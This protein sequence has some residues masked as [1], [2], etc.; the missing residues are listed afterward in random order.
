MTFGAN[1]TSMFFENG[2]SVG[3]GLSIANET[4]RTFQTAKCVI[5]TVGSFGARDALINR[6]L[7]RSQVHVEAGTAKFLHFSAETACVLVIARNRIFSSARAIEIGWTQRGL[8]ICGF[9]A[10]VAARAGN[11]GWGFSFAEVTARAFNGSFVSFGTVRAGRARN[12]IS[13][14][15]SA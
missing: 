15:N 1:F 14:S 7:V 11:H 12:T 3:V 8:I 4:R 6:A 9:I 13:F 2:R 5:R 10:I